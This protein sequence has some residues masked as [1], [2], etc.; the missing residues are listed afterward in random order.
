MYNTN[1]TYRPEPPLVCRL[2]KRTPEQLAA[3]GKTAVANR[4]HRAQI[5][6]DIAEGRRTVSDVWEQAHTD[7]NKHLG[8]IKPAS[9]LHRIPGVGQSTAPRLCEE[10]GLP[11]ERRISGMGHAQA[12]RLDGVIDDLRNMPT[13]QR[14][15]YS[16]KDDQ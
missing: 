9:I 8:K 3:S 12:S 6:D 14:V 11:P 15:T 10:L 4:R 13:S 2:P 1:R 5:M 16:P 7:E